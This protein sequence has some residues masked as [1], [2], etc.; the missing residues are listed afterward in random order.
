MFRGL[1]VWKK[2]CMHGLES[3]AAS[4]VSTVDLIFLVAAMF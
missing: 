2:T 1:S 3:L 4:S